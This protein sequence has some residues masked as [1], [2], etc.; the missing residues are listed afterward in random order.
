MLEIFKARILRY[1]AIVLDI[2]PVITNRVLG[3]EQSPKSRINYAWNL[4][5]V[6]Q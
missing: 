5:D 1:F 2:K 6:V 3:H 4:P